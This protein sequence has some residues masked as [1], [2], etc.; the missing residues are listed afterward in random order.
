MNSNLYLSVPEITKFLGS[1]RE[2]YH[3][4]ELLDDENFPL[5]RLEPNP[6]NKHEAWGRRNLREM[7]D[8]IGNAWER[9]LAENY[10]MDIIDDGAVDLRV[11]DGLF[12]DSPVQAKNCC[13]INSRGS[14]DDGRAKSSPG[15]AYMRHDNMEAFSDFD[16]SKSDTVDASDFSRPGLVHVAVHYPLEEMPDL[17]EKIPIKHIDHPEFNYSVE[18]AY[19]G[20]IVLPATPLY[21]DNQDR[22]GNG[23]RGAWPLKWTELFG[24]REEED[25]NEFMKYWT[26]I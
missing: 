19:I 6:Q 15:V 3:P 26:K 2:Q 8:A 12:K 5:E 9:Y 25:R 23:D 20:E 4:R 17:T 14:Y 22:F 11:T 18:T 24:E 13:V 1:R 21:E 10:F 16:F 7:T